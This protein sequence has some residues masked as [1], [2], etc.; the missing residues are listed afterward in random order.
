MHC[1]KRKTTEELGTSR[2]FK[3]RCS[4]N[5]T[6]IQIGDMCVEAANYAQ[7]TLGL[8]HSEVTYEKVIENYLYDNRIPTRRQV[9]FF[10]HVKNDIIPTGILDLEVDRCV[11]LELKAGLSDITQDHIVQ[12]DRYMKSAGKNYTAR[13][14]IGMVILFSK[15]GCVKIHQQVIH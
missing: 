6:T 1:Q 15:K 10:E 3:K 7:T 12:L 5:L 11:L 4:C 8:G 2:F 14:L 9:R 13:P